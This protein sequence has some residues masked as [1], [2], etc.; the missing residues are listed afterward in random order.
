M[1][2]ILSRDPARRC[3]PLNEWPVQDQH[4]WQA[5]LLPG[6]IIDP[7]GARARFAHHSNRK[8]VV[9]YGRWLQWLDH[10]GELDATQPPGARI[11]PARVM[12]YGAALAGY[13]GTQTQVSRLEELYQVAEVM[14][15]AQDWSWIRRG[16]VRI[17]ARHVPARPKASRLVGADEL[18]AAGLHLMAAAEQSGTPRWQACQYRDGLVI[19]FLAARPLRRRN[20]AGLRIGHS[21]IRHGA[22]W[23]IDIPAAETKTG[24]PIRMPLSQ[25]MSAAMDRYL[26]VHRPV[27]AQRR[28]Y[29]W[30]EPGAALWLSSHGSPMTEIALYDRI[31]RATRI[32]LGRP[33]NP[34][35]FR[36][37]AATALAIEDPDH[38]RIA[39]PL[40]GHTSF[41]TTERFYNQ[42]RGHQAAHR[43]QEQVVARRKGSTPPDQGDVSSSSHHATRRGAVARLPSS[44]S[45][46][47]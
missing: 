10:A 3:K 23:W 43:W 34:H 35:L 31:I 9:G 1:T 12:A 20:L 22:D 47:P 33:I 8:L 27:L 25:D 32:A 11:T 5:A 18:Y 15:P 42:A 17:R 21:L 6:D 36:D 30:Q 26:T 2:K 7:G 37:C 29:W 41:A 39:A 4:L 40:L 24:T 46:K 19:A 38:V 16:A 28:G 13:N 14:D 44:K 45:A